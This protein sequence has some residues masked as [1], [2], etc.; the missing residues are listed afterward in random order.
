[1]LFKIAASPKDGRGSLALSV[2]R[3][4]VAGPCANAGSESGIEDM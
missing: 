1:M 3:R 4:H 2:S